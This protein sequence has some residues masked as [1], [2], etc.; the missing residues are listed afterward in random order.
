MGDNFPSFSSDKELISGI[1]K[2]LQQLNTKKIMQLVNGQIN[3]RN[4]SQRKYKWPI[5]T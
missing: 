3:C 1:Y 4:T 2:E 5:N